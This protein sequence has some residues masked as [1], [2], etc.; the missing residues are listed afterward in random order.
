MFGVKR[1]LTMI[2]INYL[3]VGINSNQLFAEQVPKK[4]ANVWHFELLVLTSHVH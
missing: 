4:P 1:G 2:K 3:P